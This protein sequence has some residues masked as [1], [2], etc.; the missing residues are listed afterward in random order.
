MT[1]PLHVEQIERDIVASKKGIE[2]ARKVAAKIHKE[3]GT[4][5]NELTVVEVCDIP[6]SRLHLIYWQY[7]T[8]GQT[9][10]R[11]NEASRGAGHA[12]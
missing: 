4:I 7:F 1:W 8:V 6:S 5:L 11:C 3:R 10:S 2:D 9:R 12:H